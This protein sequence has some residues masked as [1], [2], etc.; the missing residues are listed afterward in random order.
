MR[1]FG[2]TLECSFEHLLRRNIPTSIE[3]DDAAIVK[4]V[5]I[6][7]ENALS[8]QAR[9]RNREIRSRACS[10]FCYLRV[11]V[12]ENPKLVPRLSKPTACK[13]LMCAFE[14]NQ[15]C[16]LIL[17]WRSWRWRRSGRGSNCSN[18]GLLL[19]RFDP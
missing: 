5:G 7:W 13:L 6:T 1:C 18:R 19:R 14:R 16:R 8:S 9:L 10:D 12:Y 4:R 2:L 11:F 17:C 3:L 15:C